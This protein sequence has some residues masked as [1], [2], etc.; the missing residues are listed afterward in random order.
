MLLKLIV[1]L[2]VTGFTVNV[3]AGGTFRIAHA[4]EYGGAEN[5]NPFDPNRFTPTIYF[6]YSR[7]VRA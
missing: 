4:M 7:L 6:L 1:F 5:L 2:L 3:T